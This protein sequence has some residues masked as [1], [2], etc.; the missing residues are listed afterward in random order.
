[1]IEKI[2]NIKEEYKFT[3]TQLLS[4]IASIFVIGGI[5]G[6]IYETIFYRIDLGYFVK[7]GST[8]GPW[9]P[10]YGFG[11]LFIT[12]F[13]YKMRKKPLLVFLLSGLI[14]GV[15]E[16]ATGYILYNVWGIRLWDYNTE[17]WNFGNIG[18][19]ICLRSILFFA[20]SGLFLIYAILPFVKGF[21]NK[22]K[23]KVFVYI[24]IILSILFLVDY[25]TY[26]ILK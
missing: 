21:Y 20:V 25:A 12:M 22:F 11:S 26:V 5:F 7:R 16:F 1:M 2:E 9:I 13:C 3:K 14:S 18:G 15:L 17:I 6:F 19:Y 23:N 10:I 8:I 4:I 24:S